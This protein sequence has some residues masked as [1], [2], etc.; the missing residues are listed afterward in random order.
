[1][2]DTGQ[3][4]RMLDT[5]PVTLCVILIACLLD[6]AT[7]QDQGKYEYPSRGNFFTAKNIVQP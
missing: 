2:L 4:V 7:A 6:G 1:M 5:G 3:A